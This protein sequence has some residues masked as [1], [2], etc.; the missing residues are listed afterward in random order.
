MRACMRACACTMSNYN[1]VHMACVKHENM[2]WGRGQANAAWV[3]MLQKVM[4]CQCNVTV[5]Y[6]ARIVVKLK[7]LYVL[8]I[9]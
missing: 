7:I 1:N 2:V 4:E 6:S 3:G 9:M 5:F 8:F